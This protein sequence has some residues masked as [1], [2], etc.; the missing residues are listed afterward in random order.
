MVQ[1]RSKLKYLL[2]DQIKLNYLDVKLAKT[3]SLSTKVKPMIAVRVGVKRS[4]HIAVSWR[5]A[6]TTMT[7]RALINLVTIGIWFTT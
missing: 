3:A 5:K 4:T 2:A 7:T 1:K 6:M